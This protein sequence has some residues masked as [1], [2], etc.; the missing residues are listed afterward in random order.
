MHVRLRIRVTVTYD[1]DR[2]AGGD[3]VW[4]PAVS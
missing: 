2:D 1:A 3:A 4:R